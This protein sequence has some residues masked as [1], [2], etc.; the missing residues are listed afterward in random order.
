MDV[1]T[2][3]SA[4]LKVLVIDGCAANLEVIGKLL[5]DH[6]V[7]ALL[8]TN[9]SRGIKRA[10]E[11]KPDLILLEAILPDQDGFEVM[12]SLKH[13]PSLKAT[14]VILFSVC[15]D[16]ISR[17]KALELGACD[18][19]PKPF[20]IEKTIEQV[21]IILNRAAECRSEPT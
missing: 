8:E 5:S 6:G 3:G 2:S 19:I 1:S 12:K 4:I 7:L 17:E 21:Q 13:V 14:P 18:T 11:E 15:T 10:Q 20:D 9:G 16:D